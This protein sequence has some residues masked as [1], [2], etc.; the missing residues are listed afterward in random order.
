[1]GFV[2]KQNSF[3]FICGQASAAPKQDMMVSRGTDVS[4]QVEVPRMSREPWKADR[5]QGLLKF[6]RALLTK[7]DIEKARLS[8]NFTLDTKNLE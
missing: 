2:M 3:R 6:P 4:P 8:Q 7:V 5:A 1:M